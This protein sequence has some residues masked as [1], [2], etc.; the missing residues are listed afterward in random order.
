MKSALLLATAVSILVAASAAPAQ[1]RD[2][3][4][5]DD[6]HRNSGRAGATFFVDDDFKGRSI[7][8]DRPVR[9]FRRFGLNDKISSIDLRSGRWLVCVD[10]D[11]QGRCQVIDQSV[12][13]L[14]RFGLDDQISS[15]RPLSDNDRS[16]NYR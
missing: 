16:D 13:K 5:R 8:L 14:D 3:N 4:N 2:R 15:A 1:Y 6:G 7:Y 10:D 9:S 11:F 12:R